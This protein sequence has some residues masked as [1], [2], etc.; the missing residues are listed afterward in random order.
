MYNFL[1]SII[2]SF[3]PQNVLVKNEENF[4]KIL[5][6]LYKGKNHQC[7]V[8]ETQ[9][10]NFA[11]LN[12]GDLICPVCGSI[13]RTRRLYKL[14]NEEFIVPNIAILD[15]SP[16]RILY[17]KWKKK[18][19]IQY[20]A[21]DFGTDFIADYRYDITAITCK[22]ETFDLIICYHILEHIVDDK[23]AM[24]E[25][26]RVLKKNGTVLIQTPFKKGEIY[27]DYSIV[28]EKERLKHFGQEDH[29]R[30]YSVEGLETR[31]KETGFNTE[32]R[33]F[34]EDVYLGLQKN[35]TV[36]ICKK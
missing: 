11:K 10:K 7:N 34:D 9:L 20:F 13:S 18:N 26:Y 14:L 21:T 33:I 1:K 6:P 30:I 35:E 19:N 22:D 25:L 15:F 5:K 17:R 32:I 16:F 23:K 12:N 24:S 29:V 8:C 36:I 4:R 28:T 27:E 2:K 3:I 31:L